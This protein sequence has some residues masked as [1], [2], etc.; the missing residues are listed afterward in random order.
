MF[1]VPLVV[2]LDFFKIKACRPDGRPVVKNR[3]DDGGQAKTFSLL[4][5]FRGVAVGVPPAYYN[6]GTGKRT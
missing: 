2:C 1:F 6:P 3:R 4:F 5:F